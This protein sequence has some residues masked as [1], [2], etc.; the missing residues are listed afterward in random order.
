M[1]DEALELLRRYQADRLVDRFAAA[2]QNERRDA[3]D[4]ELLG[5]LRLLIDVDAADLQLGV[6]GSD[7]VDDRGEH[8]ET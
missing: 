6:L 8:G 4:V 3:H 1:R 7:L 5:E 2:E